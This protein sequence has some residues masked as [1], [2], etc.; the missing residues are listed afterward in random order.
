MSSIIRADRWQ[1]SNGVAYNSVLQVVS[2]TKT[3]TF[4]T[5]SATYADVTGLSVTITPRFSTSRILLV[6]SITATADSTTQ[7]F[8]QFV[9]DSTAIGI[10]DAGGSR[11][12]STFPIYIQGN[13][14]NVYSS[15]ASF[16]DSPATTS[17]TTYKIQVRRESTSGTI[18]IN[19]SPNDSDSAAGGRF[20][21]TI[22][23]MEIAQ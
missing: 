13:A 6:A 19:R 17:A 12:R 15:N 16:F 11:V 2:T 9:R 18:F 7:G 22:T 14:F 20:I 8:A 10:G 3:D 5:T 4:T 1:N 23:V 21:S